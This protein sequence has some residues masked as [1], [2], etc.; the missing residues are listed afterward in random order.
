MIL[1]PLGFEILKKKGIGVDFIRRK[2]S[3]SHHYVPGD[4]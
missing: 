2:R 1:T 3:A 4:S